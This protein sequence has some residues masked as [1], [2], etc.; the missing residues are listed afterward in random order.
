MIT[1][2]ASVFD[3]KRYIAVL[4]PKIALSTSEHGTSLAFLE[5]NAPISDLYSIAENVRIS[6]AIS[7]YSFSKL[8]SLM[9]INNN[10]SNIKS[11][12]KRIDLID[13]TTDC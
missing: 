7:E 2:L 13:A 10:T 8:N 5:G 9:N 4:H 12:I 11:N 6:S 1:T 3:P